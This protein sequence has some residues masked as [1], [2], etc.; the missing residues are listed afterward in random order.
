MKGQIEASVIC[1]S[2]PQLPGGLSSPGAHRLPARCLVIKLCSYC[3]LERVWAA[4]LLLAGFSIHFE[5][6]PAFSGGGPGWAVH[7]P[8][9]GSSLAYKGPPCQLP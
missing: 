4:T 7:Q 3:S 9:S 5:G 6:G 1:T 8:H 2:G